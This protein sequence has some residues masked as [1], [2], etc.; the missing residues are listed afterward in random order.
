MVLTE[1]IKMI[2]SENIYTTRVEQS[3][4]KTMELSLR[5]LVWLTWKQCLYVSVETEIYC[6]MII[7]KLDFVKKWISVPVYFCV[8]FR[9]HRICMTYRCGLWLTTCGMV[10][11]RHEM[12]PCTNDWT[13][14]DAIWHVGWGGPK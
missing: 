4:K 8:R 12:A 13:D 11:V 14:R 3:R 2:C 5:S 9:P 6:L 10:C 1:D 7:G